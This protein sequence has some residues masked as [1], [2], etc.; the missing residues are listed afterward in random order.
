MWEKKLERIEKY[1]KNKIKIILVARPSQADQEG[2]TQA[3]P[4]NPIF[5]ISVYIKSNRS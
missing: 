3:T 5:F 2:L 1:I 4:N